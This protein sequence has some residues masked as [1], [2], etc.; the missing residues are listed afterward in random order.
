MNIDLS[1]LILNRQERETFSLQTLGNDSFLREIGGKFISPIQVEIE[2]ERNGITFIGQGNIKT[3][4]QLPCS[5]CLKE[6]RY[7]IKT[8]FELVMAEADNSN[9]VGVDS[10][11]IF[12]EGHEAD[13]E[14]IVDEAIF[15]AIPISSLCSQ[16]CLG[17]CLICGSDKNT[18][19][20]SCQQEFIDPRWE[21]LR[22]L[23]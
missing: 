8:D 11:I 6:F 14:S 15:M 9:R 7:P 20:C 1:K 3:L 10:D 12:L 13:I 21:K 18:S 17:I 19:N 5:R 2:V 22:N 16:D 4:L 23:Q